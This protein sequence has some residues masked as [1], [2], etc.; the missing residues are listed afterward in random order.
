MFRLAKDLKDVSDLLS[1]RYELSPD[2]TSVL[3]E[4]VER[5]LVTDVPCRFVVTV[6]KYYPHDSPTIRC[7]DSYHGNHLIDTDGQVLPGNWLGCHWSAMGSM[8]TVVAILEDI[9][10]QYRMNAQ[11]IRGT[12]ATENNLAAYSTAAPVGST[13][14]AA[15][16]AAAAGTAPPSY[17]SCP[18]YPT[19]SSPGTLSRTPRQVHKRFV[20]QNEVAVA[21]AGDSHPQPHP[22]HIQQ[23][24]QQ[25]VPGRYQV[26]HAT[27]SPMMLDL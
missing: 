13:A 9:R 14:A 24:H 12:Q 20:Q 17:P 15:A 21:A 10:S 3:L 25:Q 27:D 23:Q 11:N 1:V 16:A 8:L 19:S 7:L 22:Q 5:D 2:S 6:P 26:N 18:S 4:F